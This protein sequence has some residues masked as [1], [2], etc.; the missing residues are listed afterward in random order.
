MDQYTGHP[1]FLLCPVSD[2]NFQLTRLCQWP[3]LLTDVSYHTVSFALSE[4]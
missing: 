4:L 1:A 3:I 2:V